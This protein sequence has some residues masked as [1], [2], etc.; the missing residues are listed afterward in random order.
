M[1]ALHSLVLLLSLAIFCQGGKGTVETDPT[2]QDI[3]LKQ[4]ARAERREAAEVKLHSCL[5]S[6]RK[7]SDELLQ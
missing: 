1:S 6:H 2:E 3:Q 4:V 5:W 7:V